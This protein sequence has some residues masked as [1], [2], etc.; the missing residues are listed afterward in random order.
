MQRC[1]PLRSVLTTCAAR[2]RYEQHEDVPHDAH[3]PDYEADE[4]C[5]QPGPPA[6]DRGE[7]EGSKRW[8]EGRKWEGRGDREGN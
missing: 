3:S 4:Q 1:Q 7:N 5:G 2:N 8:F 6:E